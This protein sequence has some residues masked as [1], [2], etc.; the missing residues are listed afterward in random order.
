[1]CGSQYRPGHKFQQVVLFLSL[2]TTTTCIGSKIKTKLYG[3]TVLICSPTASCEQRCGSV[4]DEKAT[5]SCDADCSLFRD[6]CYDSDTC[7]F[8]QR[9]LLKNEATSGKKTK[10]F[11]TNPDS[12]VGY[13]V[14]VSCLDRTTSTSVRTKC[15]KPDRGNIL[16][17]ILVT[18]SRGN[19]YRN[20]YC[21]AC[22]GV[23]T[24]DLVAWHMT[25]SCD[26]DDVRREATVDKSESFSTVSSS[27]VQQP[28]LHDKLGHKVTCQS[29]KYTPPKNRTQPR[30]CI[31]GKETC[32][33]LY[34]DKETT[35]GCVSYA[36]VVFK[37]DV[38]YRNPH[39][40]ICNGYSTYTCQPP[41][42]DGGR[43]TIDRGDRGEPSRPGLPGQAGGPQGPEG[44]RPVPPR[45]Q[46]GPDG[47]PK[48]SYTTLD[49]LVNFADGQIS[50]Q[51]KYISYTDNPFDCGVGRVYNYIMEECIQLKCPAGFMLS[52][53]SCIPII[54]R[55][56]PRQVPKSK[57]SRKPPV[58]PDE[59]FCLCQSSEHQVRVSY[60]VNN[61]SM[62]V[63]LKDH[64][65][66]NI[67]DTNIT[68]LYATDQ[69]YENELLFSNISLVTSD[70][71]EVAYLLSVVENW[72]YAKDRA[73]SMEFI[74]FKHECLSNSDDIPTAQNNTCVSDNF[75]VDQL[76][77]HN[78]NRTRMIIAGK[79]SIHVPESGY[80]LE[81][82]YDIQN[83]SSI[84]VSFTL[85]SCMHSL[86]VSSCPLVELKYESFIK[87]NGNATLLHKATGKIFSSVEYSLTLNGTILVCSFF[88]QTAEPFG[89]SLFIYSD[90]LKVV[91]LIGVILSLIGLFLT[92]AIRCAIRELRTH[93]GKIIMNLSFALFIAQSLT[94]LQGYFLFDPV[95]C[96]VAAAVLH[97]IWLVAF[98][99]MNS[100][101]IDLFRIFRAIKLTIK[102][103]DRDRVVF[104]RYMLYSWCSPVVIVCI[105]LGVH[106][107]DVADHSVFHFK[108]GDESV[109]WIR[110]E[111][112]TLVVFGIPIGLVI[113]VNFILF[114]CT[115]YGIRKAKHSSTRIQNKSKRDQI[116]EE[117]T[118]YIR[119]SSI[120]GLTWAFG[121]LASFVDHTAIWYIFIILNT[122]QGLFIFIAF[123]INRSMKATFRNR[124][125]LQNSSTS[126]TG[127]DGHEHVNL[128]ISS[129]NP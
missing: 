52:G 39:C 46:P 55:D 117:L 32:P 2:L 50:L 106:F 13:R 125:R 3:Q 90:T 114:V 9:Q 16:Q 107:S 88:N 48:P 122:L 87:H 118:I 79:N 108:Y 93:S 37:D 53:S 69:E 82:T 102:D 115:I 24:T 116:S 105:L 23:Q 30:P 119:I 21:A 84:C 11:K 98:L 112:A 94:L 110:D 44:P 60:F 5:C 86:P 126:R 85:N 72:I 36:A 65:M 124:A 127:N 56:R 101:A 123:N 80:S 15:E 74:S 43:E 26:Y 25:A 111:F 68:A 77:V 76:I 51:S 34:R 95:V 31:L 45:P 14:V 120:M 92:F 75:P 57:C 100:M 73:T 103:S 54:S 35:N 28:M 91:N 129:K 27:S 10:C 81:M 78:F 7:H 64:V 113:I 42:T 8:P 6:C 83:D 40:V 38:A 70:C 47:P 58:T 121:F 41:Q 33:D 62:T 71:Q 29:Y 99:W 20:I 109:C 66:D 17:M 22:D 104:R 4:L 12:V 63:D 49:I 97:Y 18:N 61:S 67:V 96:S 59:T 89:R 1:M 19:I 128:R